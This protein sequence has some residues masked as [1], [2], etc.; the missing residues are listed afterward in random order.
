MTANIINF[1]EHMDPIER[2]QRPIRPSARVSPASEPKVAAQIGR[3][4][5]QRSGDDEKRATTRLEGRRYRGIWLTSRH[6]KAHELGELKAA[7]NYLH[8]RGAHA[9]F[10]AVEEIFYD[11]KHGAIG[12]D[13]RTAHRGVAELVAEDLAEAFATIIGLHGDIAVSGDGVSAFISADGDPYGL[14]LTDD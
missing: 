4:G 10:M 14:E 12:V 7:L 5:K 9:F 8:R 3:V 11:S 13:I 2:P 1:T 6:G